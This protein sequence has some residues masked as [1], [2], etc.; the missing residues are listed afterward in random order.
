MFLTKT[1]KAPSYFCAMVKNALPTKPIYLTFNVFIWR[2]R[3]KKEH[4]SQ[5]LLHLQKWL[6]MTAIPSHSNA[7]HSLF[8]D[9]IFSDTPPGADYGRSAFANQ[10]ALFKHHSMS[11]NPMR[12]QVANM[13]Q[14]RAHSF[15]QDQSFNS[16]LYLSTFNSHNQNLDVFQTNQLSIAINQKTKHLHCKRSFQDSL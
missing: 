10:I 6:P 8:S 4:W 2:T 5:L 9:D 12:A 16:T 7:N 3:S 13:I 15:P 14:Q 1:T 11:I